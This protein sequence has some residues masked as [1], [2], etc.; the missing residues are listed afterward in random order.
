MEEY[1]WIS[2]PIKINETWVKNRIVVP[3][4][5]DFGMTEKD[6]LVNNRHIKRYGEY[7]KG[8]A[9]LI[10]IE[11]CAVTKMPESRN[12]IGLYADVCLPGLE[13]L[14]KAATQKNA[15][16]L[17][18][19]M[20][21]GLCTM[22]ENSIEEINR[23]TFLQYKEDFISAA[24]RCQKAGFN[25]VELHAAHGMYLNEIL[26]TSTRKDEYGG[27]F[28]NRVRILVELI[29]DIKANCGSDFIVA[30]RFGNPDYQEL[31]QTAQAIEQA[32]ADLLDVST[33]TRNYANMPLNFIFDSKIYAASLVKQNTNLPVI[34]VGNISL[35]EQAEN[36]LVQNFSDMVAVGRGHLCDPAWTN[37]VLAGEQPI[38]C[39]NCRSCVWYKDGRKCPAVQKGE[40]I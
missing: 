6:G 32:G 37:K 31:L 15:I 26:E 38:L 16:S 35:G 29:H 33:G 1:R 17:V 11:A 19:I 13:K 7:A 23:Q 24:I 20:E 9:G 39:R 22:P 40:R 34:A 27:N 14:A 30:V 21:T 18:Q 8:G 12:T 10:I 25:G 5:A 3:P 28:E 2:K 4:M 36:V